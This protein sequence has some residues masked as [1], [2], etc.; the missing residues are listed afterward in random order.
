V[1]S[2]DKQSERRHLPF[3]VL[4]GSRGQTGLCFDSLDHA[5]GSLRGVPR[6][7]LQALNAIELTGRPNIISANKIA[8]IIIKPGNSIGNILGYYNHMSDTSTKSE[9]I[10]VSTISVSLNT[11][12]VS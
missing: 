7:S 1:F 4:I 12:G 2:S 10:R 3:L 8:Q 6:I 5:H 9:M 11:P